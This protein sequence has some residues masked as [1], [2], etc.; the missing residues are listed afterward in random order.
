MDQHKKAFTRMVAAIA[1]HNSKDAETAKAYLK[2]EGIDVSEDVKWVAWL[3]ELYRVTR[4][5]TKEP[6]VKINAEAAREW[7]DSGATPYQT[8]RETW[9]NEG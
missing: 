3:A 9:G 6:N 1:E 7:Y 4:E 8:F 2:E 5:E